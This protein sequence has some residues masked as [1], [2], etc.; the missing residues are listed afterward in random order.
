MLDVEG[1]RKKREKT[2]EESKER[3]LI[4]NRDSA[5]RSRLKKKLYVEKLENEYKKIKNEL[6]SIKMGK[7]NT[8]EG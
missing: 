6:D 2:L 7:R 8:D 5:K 4:K 1:Y 3:K